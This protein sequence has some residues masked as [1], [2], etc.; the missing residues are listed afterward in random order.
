MRETEK[1]IALARWIKQNRLKVDVPK[2]RPVA[3]PVPDR[4]EGFIDIIFVRK[5]AGATDDLFLRADGGVV[6]DQNEGDGWIKIQPSVTTTRDVIQ[7]LAASVALAEQA[8][9]AA[10][11]GNMEGAR[12]LAQLSAD[13]MIGQ[14][15]MSLL[16][17]PVPMPVL[18]EG[19]AS[20]L[21]SA[22]EQA[23]V[24]LAALVVVES[25]TTAISQARSGLAAAEP[26]KTADP[27]AYKRALASSRA[28]EE[29]S[30]GNLNRLNQLL[31]A[32]RKA[33]VSLPDAAVIIAGLGR[34]GSSAGA[35]FSP[36]RSGAPAAEAGQQPAV[37]QDW[38]SRMAKWNSELEE[39]EKKIAT[40]RAALLRLN[41][42]IQVDRKQ[43]EQW[44]QDG[45]AAF[46]KCVNMAGDIAVDFGVGGLSERYDT[47]SELA[48]NLPGQP[49]DVIEKYRH[50]AALATRMSQAKATSDLANLAARENKTE[51]ELYETLRDG[52][53]QLAGLLQ[54]DKTVP[55]KVWKYGSLAFDLAYNLTELRLGWKAVTSLQENTEAQ[56]EAVK[57][58]GEM[59]RQLVETKKALRAKIEAEN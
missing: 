51:A 49:A 20:G 15:D 3:N 42:T 59:M 57:K 38:P 18:A 23:S 52:V 55:G 30:R 14:I 4:V 10:L 45:D 41:A 35:I 46:D 6:F 25:N 24:S 16:P 1:V 9:A 34:T 39:T 12:D 22:A 43:Y 5:A 8:S 36:P 7:Q 19:G 28:A 26:L 32:Y 37:A 54:L 21:P 47:I 40:T 58:L 48:K 2:A 53:G 13:A 27:E 29:K 56:R 11:N 33:P 31:A 50:L 17:E 44:E